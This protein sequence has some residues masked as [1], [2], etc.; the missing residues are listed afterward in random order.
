[1]LTIIRVHVDELVMTIGSG[2]VS[3]VYTNL[4]LDKIC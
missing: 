1:M 4:L 3:I 2:K